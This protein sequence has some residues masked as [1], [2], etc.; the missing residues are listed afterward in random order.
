MPQITQVQKEVE[1]DSRSACTSVEI[2]PGHRQR[3]AQGVFFDIS[4]FPERFGDKRKRPTDD[5]RKSP[6]ID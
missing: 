3:D 1:T 5:S 4:D 2:C 6:I